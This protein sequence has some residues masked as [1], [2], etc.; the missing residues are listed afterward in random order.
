MIAYQLVQVIRTR[1]AER[2]EGPIRTAS[3]TTLKR[4]LGG[5][6]RVTATF[7]RADGRTLDVRKATDPEPQQNAILDALAIASSAGGTH[8]AVV[9]RIDRRVQIDG[10]RPNPL[11]APSVA[12]NQRLRQGFGQAHQVPRPDRVLEQGQRRLLRQWRAG[13][14]IASRQ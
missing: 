14:R 7:K 5:R 8:T 3:W 2:G 11:L 13:G 4:I 6:Q 1:L 10:D 12:G 9:C